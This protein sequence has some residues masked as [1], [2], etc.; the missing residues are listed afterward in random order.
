VHACVIGL[1]DRWHTEG[2]GSTRLAIATA[3][4][5]PV[6]FVR[7]GSRPAGLGPPGTLTGFTWTGGS[8][9]PEASS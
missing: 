2:I 7:D 5:T 3:T 6:L 8:E 1:S 4:D 9:H